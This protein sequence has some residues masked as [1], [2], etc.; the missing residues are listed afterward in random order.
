M[1]KSAF[2]LDTEALTPF[3]ETAQTSLPVSATGGLNLYAECSMKWFLESRHLLNLH[4]KDLEAQL[5]SPGLRGNFYHAVLKSFF[6]R[7]KSEEKDGAFNKEHMEA[8]KQWIA[9]CVQSVKAEFVPGVET[10]EP[11]EYKPLLR[12]PLALPL[13]NAASK[14]MTEKL[15][16]LIDTFKDN[17][18]SFTPVMLE[19]ELHLAE[20][21]ADIKGTL[22]NVMKSTTQG[23]TVI[24][25]F[26]TSNYNISA[27]KSGKRKYTQDKK[28]KEKILSDTPPVVEDY[29][30]PLYIKL[31]EANNKG[32]EVNAASFLIINEAKEIRVLGDGPRVDYDASI[33]LCDA[34]IDT[35][36]KAARSLNFK[37]DI[38]A[39]NDCFDCDFL[40]VCRR[41]YHVK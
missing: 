39:D 40:A 7:V 15:I 11:S 9:D 41:V 32:D 12:G 33:T 22:D 5:F 37:E 29:Q 2:P 19:E 14:P 16:K 20:N 21:N 23:Q 17:F 6:E 1:F 31:Y 35:F 8:Y 3:L 28:T 30:I 13:L 10:P 36:A 24:Y 18:D 27:V 26:K 38:A 25:D 4:A 34:L